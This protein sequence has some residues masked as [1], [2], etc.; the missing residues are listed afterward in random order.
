MALLQDSSFWTAVGFVIFVGLVAWKARAPIVAALNARVER[1]ATR[2]AE[3][4]TLVAESEYMLRECKDKL[5]GYKQVREQILSKGNADADAML[6]HGRGQLE[7]LLA[8]RKQHMQQKI[9]H[10]EAQAQLEIQTLMV[11]VATRSAAT[12]LADMMQK[13]PGSAL[14]DANIDYVAQM[15]D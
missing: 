4:E 10:M 1:I 7:V 8:Q 15:L 5:A 2:I 14:I 3:S 9:A 12:V 13:A 6:A 11:A